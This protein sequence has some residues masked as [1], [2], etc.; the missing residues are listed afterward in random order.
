MRVSKKIQIGRIWAAGKWIKN[1][2]GWIFSLHTIVLDSVWQFKQAYII[3]NTIES[4]VNNVLTDL[5]SDEGG[6][7]FVCPQIYESVI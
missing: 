6:V 1:A 3:H 2:I 4:R 7:L 5:V